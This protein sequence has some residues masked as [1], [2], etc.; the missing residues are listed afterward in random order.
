[1]WNIAHRGASG[2]AP[3]NT[4]AAFSRAAEIGVRHI[5]TDLRLTKD[6]RVVAMHDASLLR[7]T[8]LPMRVS[9]KTLDEI[10]KL[11]AGKWFAPRGR[12]F[13]RER[14]PT[15]QEILRFGGAQRVTFYLELKTL[16]GRGLEQAVVSAI[17]TA[18]ATRRVVVISFH[19]A[20]LRTVRELDSTIP[21]GLLDREVLREVIL[22]ALAIGAAQ[23]LVRAERVTPKLIGEIR[24]GGLKAIAWTVNDPR[25]MRE[26][27]RAG[28]D[29]IITDYPER[30][31]EV[32]AEIETVARPR[33]R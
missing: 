27:I 3:E 23:V 20:A 9:S 4:F 1:M 16:P 29:G 10:R 26:L 14:V 13:R 2:H 6:G 22:H 12:K 25:R 32:I 7:T 31:D 33:K 18:K 8:G 28:I 24:E 17:Q 15:L 21:I 5:E 30:L 11:S 19:D